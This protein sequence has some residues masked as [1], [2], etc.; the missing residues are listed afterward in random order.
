VSTGSN[1][2]L[3]GYPAAME[4]G[5]I[6]LPHGGCKTHL[7]IYTFLKEVTFSPEIKHTRNSL[8]AA[9]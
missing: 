1:I 8:R 9:L 2:R 6:A 3:P 5:N 7:I 4:I